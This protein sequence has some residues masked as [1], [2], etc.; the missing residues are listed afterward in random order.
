M[1]T[2]LGGVMASIL[3]WRLGNTGSSPVM[4]T[5]WLRQEF[6]PGLCSTRLG[7]DRA[8]E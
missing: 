4:V 6:P 1:Y 5:E 3:N 8:R 2:C 7:I